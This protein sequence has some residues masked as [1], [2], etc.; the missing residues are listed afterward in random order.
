MV[1]IANEIKS[2]VAVN[3]RK[4]MDIYYEDN[5]V[6][7]QRSYPDMEK[8]ESIPLV[9]QDY[10]L[11]LRND[12]FLRGN[13]SI[14]VLVDEE[15]NWVSALRLHNVDNKT[16]YMEALETH[17]YFRRRGYA[18]KLV[19]SVIKELGRKGEF[20]LF[21]NVGKTNIASME[22]HKKCGFIVDS[23][24]GYDY[25]NQSYEEGSYSLKYIRK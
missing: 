15:D 5:Y 9:E 12:F 21:S 16:Y 1:C 11:Y 7:A 14:W 6:E 24:K 17:P 25:S 10:L 13:T 2:Y 4:L 22:T 23:E 20:R 3:E 8:E 18:T 19:R